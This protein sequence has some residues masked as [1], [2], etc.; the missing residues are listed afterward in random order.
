MKFDGC[1]DWCN[2]NFAMG[3][4]LS[5]LSSNC[6]TCKFWKNKLYILKLVCLENLSQNIHLQTV[7]NKTCIPYMKEWLLLQRT[8][9]SVTGSLQQEQ[10]Q[11]D[12]SLSHNFALTSSPPDQQ[13]YSIC[14]CCR[15]LISNL[16]AGNWH[17]E[18]DNS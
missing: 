2:T 6:I 8:S 15:I 18:N 3:L 12:C 5:C 10:C 9:G 17:T 11:L 1:K 14:K 16:N 13:C 4:E 7:A